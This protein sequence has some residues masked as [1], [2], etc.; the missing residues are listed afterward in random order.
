MANFIEKVE[1]WPQTKNGKS[2]KCGRSKFNNDFSFK[3]TRKKKK[4]FS[5]TN[6]Q[7]LKTFLG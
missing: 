2:G 3:T 6:K 1:R 4:K 5:E 7:R